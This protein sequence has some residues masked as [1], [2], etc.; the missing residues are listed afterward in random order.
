MS[1]NKTGYFCLTVKCGLLSINKDIKKF[2]IKNGL[3]LISLEQSISSTKFEWKIK[4]PKPDKPWL[5]T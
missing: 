1:M 3:Y 4:V 2:W 5:Q